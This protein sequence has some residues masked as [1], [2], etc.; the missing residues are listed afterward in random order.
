[1]L[2]GVEASKAD[3]PPRGRLKPAGSHCLPDPL[4]CSLLPPTSQRREIMEKC[5]QL[6]CVGKGVLE[7]RAEFL[8]IGFVP[9]TTLGLGYAFSLLSRQF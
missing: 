5:L 3:F 9:G 6:P 4:L 8:L 2:P 1:M 7:T